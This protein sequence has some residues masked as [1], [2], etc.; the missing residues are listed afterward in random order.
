MSVNDDEIGGVA[1]KY[2]FDAKAF[3][4]EDCPDASNVMFPAAT[5]L[6]YEGFSQKQLEIVRKN[7]MIFPH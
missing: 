1:R 3:E 7:L 5:G 6:P 4:I 2:Y